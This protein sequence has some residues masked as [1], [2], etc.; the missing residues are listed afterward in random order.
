M[1][2][3][4]LHVT[5]KSKTK[6]PENNNQIPKLPVYETNGY[7]GNWA[8]DY[9]DDDDEE[10]SEINSSLGEDDEK[11][12]SQLKGMYAHCPFSGVVLCK[13]SLLLSRHC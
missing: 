4:K 8:S 7:T 6:K 10:E 9:E 13:N 2:N 12:A 11:F 3:V 5:G 1:Y